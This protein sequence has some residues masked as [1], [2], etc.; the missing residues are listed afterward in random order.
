L[1]RRGFSCQEHRRSYQTTGQQQGAAEDG[2]ADASFEQ[3]EG[4]ERRG[5]A[6]QG[7]RRNPAE[8]QPEREGDQ[9]PLGC[10]QDATLRTREA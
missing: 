2:L 8:Q 10:A 9:P 7:G 5:E 6:Y 3:P 4:D 1:R